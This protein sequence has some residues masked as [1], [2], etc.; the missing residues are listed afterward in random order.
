MGGARQVGKTYLVK[1]LFAKTYFANSFVFIDC[2]IEDEICEYCEKTANPE[3]IIEFISLKKGKRLNKKTLLIFDEVQES[4][5][6]LSALKYFYQDHPKILVI[7]TRSMERTKIQHEIRKRGT[8]YDGKFLF[9]VGKIGQV[10]VYPMTFDEFLLNSNEVLYEKVKTDYENR[11][12][13]DASIHEMVLN[14]VD[15]HLLVG[16][17]PEAVEES[18]ERQTFGS[19]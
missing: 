5:N 3:K 17:M 7:A 11:I 15:K 6:I 18:F 8:N 9:S 19:T 14:K 1:N 12:P 2:K 10:T 16:G 13:L 4:P